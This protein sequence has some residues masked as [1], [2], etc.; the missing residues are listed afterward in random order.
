MHINFED[1][2]IIVYNL[3]IFL[4]EQYDKHLNLS[5]VYDIDT[6]RALLNYLQQPN[7]LDVRDVK[8][9]LIDKFTF[10]ENTPPYQI[11][12]GGGILNFDNKI[13]DDEIYFYTRPR[14]TYFDNGVMF[15][16]DHIEELKKFVLTM[17]WTV[18][19]Y[20]KFSYDPTNSGM[21]KAEIRDRKSVV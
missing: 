8:S 1:E 9:K 19:D 20:T 10:R 17:G 3:Q 16:N 11:I 13:I 15:I 12:E 7:T 5:G 21:S 18:V 14:T 4:K 6:H 2:N